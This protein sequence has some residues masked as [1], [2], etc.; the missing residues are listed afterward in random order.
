M[1][2]QMVE[3]CHKTINKYV[4]LERVEIVH[5]SRC[6]LCCFKLYYSGL[7]GFCDLHLFSFEGGRLRCLKKLKYFGQNEKYNY[8]TCAVTIPPDI[9]SWLTLC[10][11]LVNW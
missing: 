6:S 10:L 1:V 2:L 9:C 8:F 5:R 11:G 7:L 4:G 3:N